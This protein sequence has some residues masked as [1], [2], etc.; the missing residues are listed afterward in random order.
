MTVWM[1]LLD[2]PPRKPSTEASFRVCLVSPR[3]RTHERYDWSPEG[4]GIR[5]NDLCLTSW[6]K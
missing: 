5:R 1:P 3:K 6:W 2:T 4:G